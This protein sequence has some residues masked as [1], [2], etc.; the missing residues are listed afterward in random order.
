[1][2]VEHRR[3]S[4]FWVEFRSFVVRCSVIRILLFTHTLI[5]TMTDY[6][7]VALTA[8]VGI[9]GSKR[10]GSGEARAEPSDDRE[11]QARGASRLLVSLC[12]SGCST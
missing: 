10:V 4:V 12:W 8:A 11:N 3:W 2:L 6:C 5:L 1:M 9:V 7:A